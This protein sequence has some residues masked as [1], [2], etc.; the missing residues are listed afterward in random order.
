M[1]MNYQEMITIQCRVYRKKLN[2]CDISHDYVIAKREEIII[3]V[4]VL[5]IYLN[6][7]I[8]ENG[9]TISEGKEN[10]KDKGNGQGNM[11]KE[12]KQ[13]TKSITGSIVAQVNII[14]KKRKDSHTIVLPER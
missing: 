14:N 13:I 1:G 5:R 8:M 10:D 4:Q 2:A 12:L 9:V 6:K 7:R 3:Q 11:I